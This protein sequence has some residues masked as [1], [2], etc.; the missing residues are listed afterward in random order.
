ML[1]EMHKNIV[2]RLVNIEAFE[3][4]LLLQKVGDVGLYKFSNY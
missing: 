1:H 2:F 3:K 4:T